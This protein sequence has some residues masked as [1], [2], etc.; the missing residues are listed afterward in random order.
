MLMEK[1]ESGNI[2]EIGHEETK[3]RVRFKGG[4]LYEYDSV[5]KEA[6]EEFK[7][8]ESKGSHFSKTFRNKEQAYIKI[9]ETIKKAE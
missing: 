4:T 2:L 3:M 5:S 8:A 6:F 1:V 7:N 9:D